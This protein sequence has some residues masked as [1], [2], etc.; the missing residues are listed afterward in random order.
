MSRVGNL[1]ALEIGDNSKLH[2]LLSFVANVHQKFVCALG[3][4]KED[5]TGG[6]RISGC[7]TAC[8]L[9]SVLLL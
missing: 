6:W 8:L 7:G 5:S 3:Q 9:Q 4:L 1:K 2:L